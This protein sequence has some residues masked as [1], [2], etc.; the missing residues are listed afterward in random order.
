MD[1]GK[2]D[3]I[4]I[5]LLTISQKARMCKMRLIFINPKRARKWCLRWNQ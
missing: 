1:L 2:E 4:L 3:A 5:R